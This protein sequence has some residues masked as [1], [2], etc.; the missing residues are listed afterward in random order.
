MKSKLIIL[1]LLVL[2]SLSISTAG[3]SDID[4]ITIPEDNNNDVFL[5][6][7]ENMLASSLNDNLDDSIIV[8]D[9][10]GM[11]S[12]ESS[13]W[14]VNGSVSASGNGSQENPY[15]TFNE[16]VDN[17]DVKDGDTIMI[18][19]GIYAGAG[20]NV[21][22]TIKTALNIVN[23][24]LGDVI[25]DAEQNSRIFNVDA[26]SF[27][28]TGITFKN[29]KSRY[30]G[31]I[32]FKNA[33]AHSIFN[34]TFIDNYLRNDTNDSVF[35]AKGGAI[36]F[37]DTVDNCIFDGSF[38]NNTIYIENDF[39]CYGKGGAIYFSGMVSNCIF[40][41]S[42]INNTVHDDGGSLCFND[43]VVDSSFA[44][45]FS[46]NFASNFGTSIYINKNVKNTTFQCSSV[47]DIVTTGSFAFN[48][49]VSDCDFNMKITD[50]G[51]ANPLCFLRNVHDCTFNGTYINNVA[52]NG[53]VFYFWGNVSNCKFNGTYINNFAF[54]NGGV[55]YFTNSVINCTIDGVFENNI[56]QVDGSAVY[57]D[58]DAQDCIFNG[59]Y[60]NCRAQY[61]GLFYIMDGAQNSIFDGVYRNNNGSYGGVSIVNGAVNCTF[62][63]LY[64][65][66]T[67]ENLGGTHYF[68]GNVANS[69]IGG[70]YT[71][72]KVVEQNGGALFF[73]A[74]FTDS[75]INGIFVNN[76]AEG[77]GTIYVLG[78]VDNCTF[79]G[80]FSNNSVSG[81]GGALCFNDTVVDS[82]FA[83]NFSGNVA[84]EGRSGAIYIDKDVKN[85][86]FQCSAF[87]YFADDSFVFNGEVTDC[88]FNMYVDGYQGDIPVSPLN[89]EHITWI[90]SP[91]AFLSNVSDCTFNG[92]YINNVIQDGGA[93]YFLGNVSN[94]KFNGTYK[95]NYVFEN[96]GVFY[97]ANDV[98]NCTIDGVFDKNQGFNEGSIFY[99]G[100]GAQDC[101]FN[102]TYTANGKSQFGGL[103]YVMDEA[104]NCI[105]DG[106]Y[107]N[108]SAL[109]GGVS[110]FHDV[111]NCTFTGLYINNTAEN[112]GGT[113]YFKG[114]V[115]NS[116]IGG[117]YTDNKVV[118]QNG[119][120]L[121]FKANFTDSTINGIFIN[122]TAGKGGAIYFMEDVLNCSIGGFFA[123]N[124]VSSY[125]YGFGDGGTIYF[126]K[127][128][129]NSTILGEFINNT[130]LWNAGAIE[131]YGNMT[132]VF[133]LADFINNTGTWGGALYVY[134]D[135]NNCTFAGDF[136]N[137]TGA[138]GG[139]AIFNNVTDSTI[140]GEFS[141]NKVNYAGGALYF[142]DSVNNSTISG[143]FINN[144]CLNRSSTITV[145]RPDGSLEN[146]TR[147]TSIG[148]ALYF[149]KSVN[150][151]SIEGIFI[152]NSARNG[153]AI[154]FSD[155]NGVDLSGKYINNTGN[156]VI[157]I[158]EANG[159]N[160][161][162]DSIFINNDINILSVES[163]KLQSVNNWFGNN[164][165]NYN[166]K[167][168][169]VNVDMDNWL[170]LNATSNP[171]EDSMDSTS[172]ITF[173][174]ESYNETSNKTGDYDG[175]MDIILDLSST[176][177]TLNQTTALINEE[178]LY[179]P[180]KKG[181]ASI[182][183]KFEN[184][185]DTICLTNI[186]NA[187]MNV[188]A[189]DITEGENLT[190][191]VE[192]PGDATG[193]VTATVDGVNFTS[194]VVNGTATITVP[195]LH[196]GNYTVPVTYSGDDKYDPNTKE[197]NVT[198]NEDTSDIIIA[199]DVTKYY[200]GPERFVVTVTD[201]EGNPLAN[202][203]VI[204]NINGRN[205]NRTTDEN[206][207]AS[208]AIGLPSNTYNV[209]V[210][211]DNQSVKSVVTVLSTVN[212]TDVV[213]MYR[214][215]TQYYAT[216]IDT[217]GKYLANGTTVKF[218][219]NGVMYERKVSGDEGLARLNINLPAGEYIITAI[220]PVNGEMAAN[221]I[222]VLP[223]IVEN[224]D[225]TKY[226]KNGTQY[227]FKVLDDNGNP[228]GAGVNVT[229]NINGVF[230]TR[231]TNE[232][233]I[234]T[235]SINLIPGDYVITAEYNG[236]K[237]ANNITVL[238]VLSAE[239]TTL[240]YNSSS[241]FVATLLDG[242]GKPYAEQKLQFNINGV[243]YYRS[244][245]SSGQAK[246]NINLPVGEYIIT[247]SYNGVN[248]A[249]KITIV[250]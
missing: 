122:N 71:D 82:S 43:T 108:N 143:E 104:K 123:L 248:I 191:N 41:G 126:T 58:A 33:I 121:F 66:N 216:F 10:N 29:G 250:S 79:N 18:A 115:V 120:A 230:Y 113:H 163:G 175:S 169:A 133:V 125:E 62:T 224:R 15:K 148:G 91:I 28:I 176:L 14:Y 103:F 11:L 225:I 99:M 213:K 172:A 34:G 171:C 77:S 70:V 228:V 151:S 63:G 159:D 161:V 46:G 5:V 84:V 6:D 74:N 215:G 187:T 61:G 75:T 111:V 147:N 40:G 65:N 233:G 212:G 160:I 235:L 162:H 32:Y 102:G 247:S 243:L 205:Y 222:T 190:V 95:E 12:S 184:A 209:T 21:N 7:E 26:N 156:E 45:N 236:F 78:M 238:P 174:L 134:G 192:L 195:D 93:F 164:A 166:D 141:G 194:D 94:C 119:G 220:N 203:T 37:A 246:L 16:V 23:W 81:D 241:Q 127:N 170:F 57:M 76:S 180:S 183:G 227:T 85:T 97:F 240:K 221:N 24:T 112:L 9:D 193:N 136:I 87:K 202:K 219:I 80:S 179:A 186:L 146:I 142:R 3:A 83:C 157:H 138:W 50:F 44:C 60:D 231:Q 96:A 229:F 31:A 22:L 128:L 139:V 89:V 145:I 165:T 154:Y 129:E 182:T 36:Y 39:D 86:T 130:A 137:N 72:N 100:T 197:I 199:P 67:A 20:E 210:T 35:Y 38:I 8:A 109:Y 25:F 116:T 223:T 49:E 244:T 17:A 168:E 105:I 245:D 239:D 242:Q 152:N 13:I 54:E 124:S 207:T 206:G 19:P 53:G 167:P 173:K 47:E 132:N 144:S 68:K 200:K 30:G 155:V 88:D 153:S 59:T 135:M 107:R 48:G 204:I 234:A 4:N 196:V 140:S 149:K 249:N 178:V 92:T 51:G 118:E 2:I 226:Y 188:T 211:V 150:S 110:I 73:K 55:F 217:E 181:N 214:N 201:Y 208:M 114:N 131:V 56:A 52:Q 98:I 177:G 198:V 106:V 101:I 90:D 189:D 27:N 158:I 69:T 218:N 1:F 237:V 232:S 185:Y 42:F 117:V 64:I